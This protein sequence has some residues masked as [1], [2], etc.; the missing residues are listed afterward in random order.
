MKSNYEKYRGKCKQFSEFAC[1][2]NP[3]LTLVRGHY[4]C[5][6]W[7][8]QAH[9]WTTYHDGSIYDPTVKQFPSGGA[10]EYV[11]FNGLVNC[12]ECGKEISEEQAI[13]MS[14]Y[15]VCSDACAF[16]LVGL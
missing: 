2:V 6:L 15:A 5:P 3:S 11:K 7:G 9:W 16:S 1:F 8:E 12:Y 4:H 10:G 13:I 14:N